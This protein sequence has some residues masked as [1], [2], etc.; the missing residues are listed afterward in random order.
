MACLLGDQQA[1]QEINEDSQN[2][3]FAISSSRIIIGLTLQLLTA[4]GGRWTRSGGAPDT[5]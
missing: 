2:T 1:T 5:S 4:L 3:T